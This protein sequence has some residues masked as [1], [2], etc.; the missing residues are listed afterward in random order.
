MPFATAGSSA[1]V[2]SVGPIQRMSPV[3]A[4]KAY[5]VDF[6]PHDE[7]STWNKSTYGKTMYQGAPAVMARNMPLPTVEIEGPAPYVM[8]A[9]YPNG[10]TG[11]AME[12][13]VRPDKPWFYPRARVAVK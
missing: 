11:I 10:A 5:N 13:R 1:A 12:G 8:A 4:S 2:P 6:F 7:W 9:T 3:A